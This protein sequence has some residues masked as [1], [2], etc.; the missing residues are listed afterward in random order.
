[1]PPRESLGRPSGRREVELLSEWFDGM[2]EEQVY[3]YKDLLNNQEQRQKAFYQS[4]VLLTICIRDLVRQVSVH[5]VERGAFMEKIL[6][7]Y[8][9][10]YEAELRAQLYELGKQKERH[11]H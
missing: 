6:N 5:C 11:M 8:L 2:M 1:V 10:I 9:G 3:K 4:K 7:F